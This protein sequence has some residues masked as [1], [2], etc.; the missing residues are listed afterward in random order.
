VSTPAVPVHVGPEAHPEI[1]SA[2]ERGGGRIVE[3]ERARALVWLDPFSPDLGDALGDDVAWV[4]LP[5][6]GVGHWVANG[7]IDGQRTFTGAQGVYATMVA[8]HALTL[9]LAGDR[10]IAECARAA[11]WTSRFGRP[12][13]GASVAIVGCG[14]IGEELIRFLRPF[15]A[16]IH[17]ITRSGRQVSGATHSL[18]AVDVGEVWPLVDHVV[19]AAPA[20]P[21]TARLVDADVL[22]SMRED[23]W[24]TNVGR[25]DLVDTEALLDALEA[26][27]IA[28]AALDVTDPEP[29]PDD[30]P[31]WQE[32]RA[33]VT[34]HSANPPERMLRALAARV[35]ANLRRFAAGEALLGV[36]DLDR[37]Y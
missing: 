2:V 32:P 17:A 16:E 10:R 5:S 37:G 23:A 36:V 28:G 7:V 25:G 35:T 11:S 13:S 26:G 20:T 12:L 15:D 6:A 33:L 8:E 3:A 18:P 22:A 19:L 21:E 29:L 9:M 30:H 1:V 31:L 24:L 34:P 27:S 14:G 4:Q